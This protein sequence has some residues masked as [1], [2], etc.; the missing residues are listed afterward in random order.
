[1]RLKENQKYKL[2]SSE[3]AECN[4]GRTSEVSGKTKD[5]KHK[6]K[7]VSQKMCKFFALTHEL[8]INV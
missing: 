4:D 2:R 6:E 3:E 8:L 5:L 1:M 7:R